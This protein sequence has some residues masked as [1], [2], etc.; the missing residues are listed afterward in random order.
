[1]LANT[2]QQLRA[3]IYNLWENGL[4]DAPCD[5][6]EYQHSQA[7]GIGCPCSFPSEKEIERNAELYYDSQVIEWA[8]QELS[9]CVEE[10]KKES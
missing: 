2:I 8:E 6:S 1:M 9:F 3:R 5:I 4:L 7:Q 10:I